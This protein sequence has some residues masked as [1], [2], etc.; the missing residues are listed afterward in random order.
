MRAVVYARYSSE[1]QSPTS[2]AD[3]FRL[4]EARALKDGFTVVARHSDSEVSGS[5]PLAGRPGAR[6]LLADFAAERFEALLIEGLDRLSRDQVEQES[7]VRRLEYRGV[8]IIGVSD[9]YD[10][11][12]D[13]RKVLR[14][15]R[16][17]INEVFLDDLRKKTHR[18]QS[19]QVERGFLAGGR[20]YGYRPVRQ[21]AGTVLEVDEPEAKW[22]RFIYE[23]YAAGW[24]A[25]KI[26]AHLNELGVPSARGGTW[27]VSAIFGGENKGVGILHNEL[28][29][30]RHIWNRSQWVKDPDTGKRQRLDRPRSDWKVVAKPELRIVSEQHWNAVRTRIR[31]KNVRPG[32]GTG[33]PARTLFGGLMNCPECGGP[34]IAVN[35]RQYGCGFRKDRGDTIC[36]N[37]TL[38]S[39]AAVDEVLLNS[40]RV[41]LADAERVQE[42]ED[43][44]RATLEASVAT[45]DLTDTKKRVRALE[46]EIAR[47]VEALVSVG[48]SEAITARLSVAEAEKARLQRTLQVAEAQIDVE[49]L[50]REAVRGFHASL[51]RIEQAVK[52]DIAQAREALRSVLGPVLVRRD[53]IDGSVYLEPGERKPGELS[54]AGLSLMVVAGEGFEPSTFGL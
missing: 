7:T 22:V 48:V 31:E 46:T 24:S 37:A 45:T 34:F 8:R 18:G 21:E 5:V 27:A 10:S 26:A 35:A 1:N 44:L 23:Q 6:A 19:G 40:I 20:S 39:R 41:Q 50:V 32:K 25:R 53:P 36:S 11:L 47:L 42:F 29:I 52:A 15:V 28:Y 43:A 38:V 2:V 33:R 30:G 14:G 54:L 9:G 4:C 13:G 16:G 12:S 49:R 51:E 17:L 3:Q